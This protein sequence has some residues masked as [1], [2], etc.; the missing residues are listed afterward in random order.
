MTRSKKIRNIIS[1]IKQKKPTK[2]EIRSFTST[3]IELMAESGIPPKKR[4]E[5]YQYSQEPSYNL[6]RLIGL[7]E[8]TLIVI[9]K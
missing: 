8:D 5:F 3:L 7:A 1:T 6:D 2:D 4:R 9:E